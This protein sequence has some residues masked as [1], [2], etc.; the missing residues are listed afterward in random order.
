MILVTNTEFN[1]DFVASQLPR[2]DAMITDPPYSD[3]VHDNAMS[4]CTAGAGPVDRDLGFDAL[5]SEAQALTAFVAANCVNRWSVVFSDLE[6][7]HGWRCAMR[8]A[9]AEYLRE[10]PWV[11]WA[12]PQ[13]SGD[14][15][16]SGAEAVLHF[17]AQ[18]IGP[19]GGV[20]PIAKQWNGPGSLTHYSRRSLR[21][22]G[23]H[24][25]EKPLALALDLVS[26]FS[27]PGEVVLDPFGGAGTVAQACRLLGRSCV[28]LE[29]DKVWADFADLR[30]RTALTARDAKGLS[31]WAETTFA[32]AERVPAP[33]AAD[34][35]DVRTWERA[36]RRLEDV[37]T[38]MRTGAEIGTL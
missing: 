15:P 33:K 5:T 29:R 31:E 1:S 25:T 14:R 34:G 22:S 13:L 27:A 37:L 3:H 18:T 30:T 20:Y 9:G 17:H 11:R 23:K 32:D 4:S 35:S 21:G 38:A 2:V 26:Y 24:P 28:L 6:G 7:A 16:C 8:D 10:I 19:R 12:Q 36:Q